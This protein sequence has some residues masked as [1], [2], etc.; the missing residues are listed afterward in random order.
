MG[1][2]STAA[3]YGIA[4]IMT[5][6]HHLTSLDDIRLL[7]L[8]LPTVC[9]QA[10]MQ[11]D[12]RDPLLTKPRGSLG[13]LEELAHWAAGWQHSY[14]PSSKNF[15]CHI[16]AGNHGIA[17]HG[18]SA[19]PQEAT[20]ILV[21]CFQSGQATINQLCRSFGIELQAHPLRLNQKTNDFT[22]GP[23]LSEEA[24]LYAFNYGLN[25][26][27]PDSNLVILGEMGIG[28]TSAAS[29]IAHALFGED[30]ALWVGRG[31]GIDDETLTH[32]IHLIRAAVQK[33]QGNLKDPLEILRY[34]GG[35]ELV[36]I[37]GAVIGARIKKVPVMLDGLICTA[38]AAPL[39]I[40]QAGAL[41]HCQIAH[42]SV[43]PGHI[44]I[45]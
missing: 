39:A 40:Q 28:N 45:Q 9:Q 21:R 14:P 24:F 11:V 38:A 19:F 3:C 29:A 5:H 10:Q 44:Q 8:D 6:I 20:G 32:K 7:L 30:A 15:T 12:L 43:E 36:A 42:T 33:H 18:V 2:V 26:I 35:F 22:K 34:F 31:S 17:D 27:S 13:R 4:R 37:A 23:A 1:R 16:Y 41:D 25:S